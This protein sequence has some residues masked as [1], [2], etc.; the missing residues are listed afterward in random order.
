MILFTVPHAAEVDCKHEEDSY[1]EKTAVSFAHQIFSL[2]NKPSRLVENRIISRKK[3]DLNRDESLQV[4]SFRREISQLLKKEGKEKI[5][6]LVD[7][8]S[9]SEATSMKIVFLYQDSKVFSKLKRFI[10]SVR[11]HRLFAEVGNIRI[12]RGA[13]NSI[14]SEARK[15]KVSALLIE[16]NEEVNKN[17]KDK[18]QLTKFVQYFLSFIETEF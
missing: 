18:E 6:L 2:T 12:Y 17:V 14:L 11:A 3:R 1:C 13:R 7:I 4:T 16:I 5:S 15:T 10:S 9:F 8:H